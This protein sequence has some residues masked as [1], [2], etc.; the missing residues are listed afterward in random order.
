MIFGVIFGWV[1]HVRQV[2]YHEGL[3]TPVYLAP[4]QAWNATHPTHGGSLG[5]HERSG[6]CAASGINM[7]EF[8]SN[9]MH[10][11]HAATDVGARTFRGND[12]A[13]LI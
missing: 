11:A 10:A 7:C 12:D 9:H 1:S 2:Y 13:Q 5:S 8:H 4:W 3:L 6:G